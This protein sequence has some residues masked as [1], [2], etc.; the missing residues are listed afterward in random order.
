MFDWNGKNKYLEK[1]FTPYKIFA[2]VEMKNTS[3]FLGQISKFRS[4]CYTKKWTYKTSEVKLFHA[5]KIFKSIENQWKI[6]L[7]KLDNCLDVIYLFRL[8]FLKYYDENWNPLCCK[9]YN[10]LLKFIYSEKATKFCEIFTLLLT[11]ST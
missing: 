6:H 5:K 2:G 10:F 1:T 4:L 8:E 3:K 11:G 7:M 9:I